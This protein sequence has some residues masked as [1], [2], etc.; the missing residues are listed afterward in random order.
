MQVGREALLAGHRQR[1]EPFEGE[2]EEDGAGADD[3]D[4]RPNRP[5]RSWWRAAYCSK[6]LRA[7][8]TDGTSG[9]SASALTASRARLLER[10]TDRRAL[11]VLDRLD[12]RPGMVGH[13][14]DRGRDRAG[15]ADHARHLDDGALVEERQAAAVGGVEDQH[16]ALVAGDRLTTAIASAS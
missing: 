10:G 1:L 13:R 4:H 6:M 15:P 16:A 8:F 9:C 2:V 7:T 3:V 12:Q 11:D 14:A 5:A